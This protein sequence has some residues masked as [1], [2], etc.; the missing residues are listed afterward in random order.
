[1]SSDRWLAHRDGS[2]IVSKRITESKLLTG[3][4]QAMAEDALFC[5][6]D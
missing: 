3:A 4:R 1:M 5:K 2:Y 6:L